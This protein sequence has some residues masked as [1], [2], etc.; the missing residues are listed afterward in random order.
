MVQNAAQDIR[1]CDNQQSS[2]CILQY[3]N[4]FVEGYNDPA[5]SKD[6]FEGVVCASL[7]DT[8]L[9]SS[10]YNIQSTKRTQRSFQFEKG[11]NHIAGL[12]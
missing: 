9:C 7:L 10:W 1:L 5:A 12:I 11:L 6:V 2:G 3:V 8:L 4:S